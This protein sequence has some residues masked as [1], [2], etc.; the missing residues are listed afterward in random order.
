MLPKVDLI[1]ARSGRRAEQTDRIG[2]TFFGQVR[3]WCW[4]C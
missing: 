3:P 4:S 1:Q 2:R